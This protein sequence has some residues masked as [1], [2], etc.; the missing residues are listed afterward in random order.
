MSWRSPGRLWP[1]ALEG[2]TTRMT[3]RAFHRVDRSCRRSAP[4]GGT[5]REDG[6][7][8]LSPPS[9]QGC[10]QSARTRPTGW[11]FHR[12]NILPGWRR[13]PSS[14]RHPRDAPFAGRA[15][16]PGSL[17]QRPMC[18]RPS[19]RPAALDLP[20]AVE[21]TRRYRP[22][23]TPTGCSPR[24]RHLVAG[25]SRGLSP[26]RPA[27]RFAPDLRSNLGLL[28]LRITGDGVVLERAAYAVED[29]SFGDAVQHTV[30]HPFVLLRQGR[31]SQ[32]E[33]DVV[34]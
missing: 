27:W 26:L 11:A 24:A 29:E 10:C 12:Q 7:R 20:E 17:L 3:S 19:R 25:R 23:V 15:P 5:Q 8:T 13:Y 34:A 31:S 4:D 32:G 21:E 33:R 16:G 1:L 6:R 28:S 2:R 9:S 18:R 22:G 30:T 14:Q